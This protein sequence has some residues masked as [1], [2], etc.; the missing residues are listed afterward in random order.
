MKNYWSKVT[1]LPMASVNMILGIILFYQYGQF[2]EKNIWTIVLSYL[3]ISIVSVF[4][5]A[6]VINVIRRYLINKKNQ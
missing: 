3:F 6:S 4:F 5:F 1:A 2:E